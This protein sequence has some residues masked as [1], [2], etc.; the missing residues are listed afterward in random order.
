MQENPTQ[1]EIEVTISNTQ[2]LHARPVMRFVDL[3]STFRSTIRVKKD[4]QEVDG[5]SPMEMMLLEATQGTV[6]RLVADGEDA[7]EAV[8][9]LVGLVNDKFGEE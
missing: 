3:A 4:S 2:G 6:L 7:R 1:T 9:A 8:A 5:K